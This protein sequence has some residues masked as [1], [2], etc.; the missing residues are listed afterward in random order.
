MDASQSP[1]PASSSS[2]TS[3]FSSSSSRVPLLPSQEPRN[4]F[5]SPLRT[6]LD[7]DDGPLSSHALLVHPTRSPHHSTVIWLHGLGESPSSLRSLFHTVRLPHSRVVVPRAP[8]LPISGMDEA[9]ERCWYDLLDRHIG[10]GMREDEEGI[11]AMAVQLRA[12]IDEE[13][14]LG[15]PHARLALAGV[16]QG[17][18]LAVHV[19]LSMPEA[20]RLAGVACVSGYLPL[21]SRYPQRLTDAGRRT[22]LLVVHGKADRAIDWQWA[23]SGWELL[24]RCGVRHV[25]RRVEHAMNHQL[26]HAQFAHTMH[27]LQERTAP[28]AP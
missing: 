10:E 8:L 13:V 15:V 2:S 26:T 16:A 6:S 25:E 5:R 20:Q 11:E 28:T 4:L 24:E 18:A 14:A 21:Q 7:S 12:L 3:S 27:W 23:Q 17:G 1:S 9:E 22:P 19:A